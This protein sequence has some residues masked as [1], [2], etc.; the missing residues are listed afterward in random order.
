MVVKIT[1]QGIEKTES[2][3]IHIVEMPLTISTYK[4]AE[5]LNCLKS[6]DIE[7]AIRKLLDD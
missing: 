6:S 1:L 4:T 5:D 3:I 2:N 7:K